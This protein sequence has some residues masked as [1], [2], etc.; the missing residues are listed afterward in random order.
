MTIFQFTYA[1]IE[2][3]TD[4]QSQICPMLL[5]TYILVH[6]KVFKRGT[7]YNLNC[8]KADEVNKMLQLVIVRATHDMCQLST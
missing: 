2:Q 7:E 4:K 3:E 8:K 1:C 5:G 6:W